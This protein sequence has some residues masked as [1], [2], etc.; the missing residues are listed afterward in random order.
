[1][2]Y[3]KSSILITGGRGV[4]GGFES[5]H[6]IFEQPPQTKIDTKEDRNCQI[7][8]PFVDFLI[9]NASDITWLYQLVPIGSLMNMFNYDLTQ[10]S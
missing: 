1:M 7:E 3:I 5:A 6:V 9:Q 10:S 8:S 4:W 2:G